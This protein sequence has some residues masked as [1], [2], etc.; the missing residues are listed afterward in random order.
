VD[1]LTGFLALAV[2]VFSSF[3]LI[4]KLFRDEDIFTMLI[5]SFIFGLSVILLP[6]YIVGILLGQGFVATSWIIFLISTVFFLVSATKFVPKAPEHIGKLK[7]ILKDASRSPLDCVFVAAIVFF[8]FKYF[9]ILSIK[10]IFDWDAIG[11]Y[12]PFGRRIYEADSIPLSGY[13]Y[14]P[15]IRPVGISVLYAWMHSLSG[16]AY[17]ENFRLFPILFIIVTMLIIYALGVDFGSKKMAKIAV[18]IYILL[19][20]H[21]AVLFYASYY[22][23]LCY[24]TLILGMFFLMYKY[25]VKRETRYCLLSG[26]SLGLSILMKLQAAYFLPATLF[27]FAG[28]LENRRLRL[29]ATYL[30]SLFTSF[31]FVFFVWPDS[32]FFPG[33]PI[34]SQILASLFIFGATTLVVI[35]TEGYVKTLHMK[36]YTT[37]KVLKSALA[38]YG[39][40]A[41]IAAIWFLRNHFFTGSWV[42]S[43]QI[44]SPNRLW[45]RDFL[46]S[47]QDPISHGNI[48]TFL[49]SLVLIPFTVYV[50]GTMWIIP[51]LVGITRQV[52]VQKRSLLMIIWVVGYWIG[53]F[54][55]VF[56]HFE[57]YAL[58][59]RDLFPLAPFFSLFA[60][61]GINCVAKYFTKKHDEA[62]IIYLLVSLGFVSL[63]QSLLICDYGP[64]PLRSTLLTWQFPKYSDT[65]LSFMPS[66]LFFT[67]I[68]NA[69]I[70]S[71]PISRKFIKN[72]MRTRKRRIEV[73]VKRNTPLKNWSKRIILVVLTFSLLVA[74]YVWLTYEFSGG[75]IQAFGENQLKPIYGG[76]FTEVAPY[77]E[78]HAEDGEVII[79]T[80]SYG[81]Q[82]HLH[83]NVRVI[84]LSVPGNLAAL[85]DVIESNDSAVVLSSLR[86]YGVRYFL[87]GK[88][89]PPFTEYLSNRSILLDIVRDPRYF[90]LI[91]F[92]NWDLYESIQ[93]RK[94]VVTGWKDD[95]FTSNWTYYTTYIDGGVQN[96]EGSTYSFRSDGG[97]LNFTI[98][99][100]GH[101][102]FKYFGIP[103]I[104]TSE[105][106]YVA[107]RVKGSPNARWLFRFISRDDVG[108][109][110]PYWAAPSQNWRIYTFDMTTEWEGTFKNKVFIPD[111]YLQLKSVDSKPATVY[112]DF[113][114]VFKYESVEE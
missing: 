28:L 85:R 50:L 72:L 89:R 27:V 3:P 55:S 20:L 97:V 44:S 37:L 62:L 25:I 107:V 68:V 82:Y 83:R 100:Q 38:F 56:H 10:G 67:L 98:S 104:N 39:T 112:I 22:P 108:K 63:T 103:P 6:L 26:I 5:I 45:A 74:P 105:Y 51:K 106:R 24:N 41:S 12:L 13:D 2:T 53:Y 36:S 110:F 73:R 1:L 52:Q 42:W 75:N 64:T 69:L 66:L 76:L 91:S 17:D 88:D 33:L 81:L 65:L 31:L 86:E 48:G 92:K 7:N 90:K 35:A 78:Y 57:L 49:L 79:M 77:L 46:S 59:P 19:P 21:D 93:G 84:A 4:R 18:I 54:W 34:T 80:E 109:D 99:G 60:A 16:S 29:T 96:P 11:L 30:S 58:N 111:A 47:V 101:V 9:Y 8:I 40:T 23:D 43:F 15:V 87:L 95:S 70:F 114:M 113:Y 14:E 32:S 102:C 71:V 61:F 94:S